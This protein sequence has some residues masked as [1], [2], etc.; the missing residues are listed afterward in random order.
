MTTLVRAMIVVVLGVLVQDRSRVSFVERGGSAPEVHEQVAGLLS[1]P[2]A[3][4]MGGDAQDVNA[5]C[6]YLH[7]EQHVQALQEDRVDVEEVAGEQPFCL[8]P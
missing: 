5:S 2:G 4:G 8:Q 6:F 3:G 7:D 1:R